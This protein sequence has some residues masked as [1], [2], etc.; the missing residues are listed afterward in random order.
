MRL[1]GLRT[2]SGLRL[3]VGTEGGYVDLGKATGDE[4]LSTLRGLLAA[5]PE[6][7]EAARAVPAGGSNGGGELGPAVPE[8][9]RI[10]C[11]GRNFLEH[12]QEMNKTTSEWPEV[13]V[14]FASCVTGPFD[15][16]VLPSFSPRAD[17]EG[18]LGV[19]IGRGGR[20]IPA[21]EA[22]AA[23][24]GYV[25][26]NDVTM[27]DWQHRG[28]Q[29][30][31]GKNFEGTLPVGPELVTADEVDPLD[32][33]VETRVN[34]E[35]VQSSRTSH[36]I[37]PIPDQIE[38]LSSFLTLEPGDL[39]ATGTPSGV[40]VARDSFLEEGDVV[41][42]TVEGVGTIRNRMRRDGTPPVSERWVRMAEQA[43]SR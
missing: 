6:G 38:F 34:G 32:L 7:M 35:L 15:D 25:V 20:H 40:G 41:E 37:T 22:L 33:A 26:L 24:A 19:V 28:Q 14:R 4:R 23:V 12:A 21:A 43:V 17:Y 13:F 18:E 31:P 2:A 30:T 36:M 3:H 11:L 29:W 10:F 16:I 39:I 9:G 27:R 8:P 42:V 1:A 5:G